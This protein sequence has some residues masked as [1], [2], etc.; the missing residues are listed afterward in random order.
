MSFF[1]VSLQEHIYGDFWR[2]FVEDVFGFVSEF[3]SDSVVRA[4]VASEISVLAR[5]GV[6]ILFDNASSDILRTGGA[7][8]SGVWD[9][10][11]AEFEGTDTGADPISPVEGTVI[12]FF[13][14]FF[15]YYSVAASTVAD[16]YVFWAGCAGFS[17]ID[18]AVS[19]RVNE[20]TG[21]TAG[22]FPLIGG[23]LGVALFS[24]I[25]FSVSAFCATDR[26]MIV[27][28]I[29]WAVFTILPRL[30]NPVSADKFTRSDIFR[31]ILTG[32]SRIDFPI[33]TGG[34]FAIS[35]VRMRT[36]LWRTVFA[37]H[38]TGVI[39]SRVYCPIGTLFG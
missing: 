33:P 20:G 37:R 26:Y 29:F 7:I 27:K 4:E 24:G 18:D 25:D 14:E 19:T 22:P 23:M 30:D 3:G 31:A 32:F 10:I 9:A 21:A 11:A 36:W 16:L 38:K 15:F 12:A 39:C 17:G 1:L 35:I 8:F 5:A 13:S 6:A 34:R 2:V 28:H